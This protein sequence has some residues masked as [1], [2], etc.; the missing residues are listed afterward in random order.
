MQTP[1]SLPF[2]L[3]EKTK[4]FFV[5]RNPLRRG[6]DDKPS[7]IMEVYYQPEPG[8]APREFG[9]VWDIRGWTPEDEGKW[10]FNRST[11][12]IENEWWPAIYTHNTL[13]DL[14]NHLEET[15]VEGVPANRPSYDEE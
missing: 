12:C 5:M 11:V 2:V 3:P 6:I 14:L 4:R 13:Q 8:I 1:S 10:T 7:R 9:H 15:F